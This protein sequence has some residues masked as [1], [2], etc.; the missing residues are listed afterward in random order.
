MVNGGRNGNGEG[1][2]PKHLFKSREAFL[3]FKR[4]GTTL[5]PRYIIIERADLGSSEEDNRAGTVS[6]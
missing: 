3:S 6:R 1:N 5:R 2:P 4:Y